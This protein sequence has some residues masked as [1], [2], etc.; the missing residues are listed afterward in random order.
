MDPNPKPAS[1]FKVVVLL[2]AFV[3]IVSAGVLAYIGMP[4]FLPVKVENVSLTNITSGSLSLVWT[5]DRA[6]LASV[7]VADNENFKDSEVF[8]DDRDIFES[9][10]NEY[11]K[12]E[13]T[14]RKVHHVTVRGLDPEKQYF[15]RI[16]NDGQSEDAMRVTTTK[17]V[18]TLQTPD[19][20]YG[21]VAEATGEAVPEGVVIMKKVAADGESQL[22]SAV[23]EEGSYS[24]DGGNMMRAD[25][26]DYF[27][28]GDYTQNLQVLG[29]D[30]GLIV[31]SFDVNKDNDQPVKDINIQASEEEIE[32][33]VQN[34][35]EVEVEV[36][37]GSYYCNVEIDG[38]EYSFDMYRI[39]KVTMSNG[40]VD[41]YYPTEDS[42]RE[43][44]GGD[45]QLYQGKGPEVDTGSDFIAYDSLNVIGSQNPGDPKAVYD[46]LTRT[47]EEYYQGVDALPDAK[48]PSQ[49]YNYEKTCEGLSVGSTGVYGGYGNTVYTLRK[50][51]SG[52]CETINVD[53]GQTVPYIV[54][55]VNNPNCS[56]EGGNA[57][58]LEDGSNKCITGNLEVI[59]PTNTPQPSVTTTATILPSATISPTYAANPNLWAKIPKESGLC[60]TAPGSS[61]SGSGD[62]AVMAEGSG[63]KLGNALGKS[64]ACSKTPIIRTVALKNKTILEQYRNKTGAVTKLN[65][66]V[67]NNAL[68]KLK[69]TEEK[70]YV[71]KQTMYYISKEKIDPIN[72]SDKVAL[73]VKDVETVHKKSIE[74]KKPVFEIPENE[75]PD[76][77]APIFREAKEK[78]GIEKLPYRPGET[79]TATKEALKDYEKKDG[80]GA[81]IKKDP[82][83]EFKEKD[84]VGDTLT[85]YETKPGLGAVMQKDEKKIE[86]TKDNSKKADVSTKLGEAIEKAKDE[87]KKE[88]D[89]KE[90]SKQNT[91]EQPKQEETKKEEPKQNTKEQPKQ[92]ETK[93]EQPK[94]ETKPKEDSKPKTESKS[95][96]VSSA[97]KNAIAKKE[98]VKEVKKDS[99]KLGGK[100]QAMSEEENELVTV[101]SE[102]EFDYNIMVLAENDVEPGT[103]VVSGTDAVQKEFAVVGGTAIVYF[104][105]YNE[106]GIK[107]DDEPLY[108]GDIESLDVKFEKVAESQNFNLSE[109]WNL[110]SFPILLQGENSSEILTAYDLINDMNDSGFLATHVYAYR[111][112]GF[113]PYSLRE[114][115][116]GKKVEFGEKFSIMPGEAYFVRVHN[117]G[118]YIVSGYKIDGSQEIALQNGWNLVSIYNSA[119]PVYA[120][121]DVLTQMST[122]GV[123]ADVL[124]KWESGMYANVIIQN[125]V[126]YGNDFAVFPYEGY[127]L[128]VQDRGTGKFKPV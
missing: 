52:I 50:R 69:E 57:I 42:V 8:Y 61:E 34:E 24:M 127:F 40:D 73:F 85:K 49:D 37:G 126:Q 5:S 18:E 64:V 83:P 125:G 78:G 21:R 51:D 66:G 107:Q 108:D 28:A 74:S 58:I 103:Y 54:V 124:S 105:D 75:I 87:R 14:R 62:I 2:L 102:E 92:E 114:D 33:Q 119:K 100:M 121:F 97:I 81:V 36:Y 120:S 1:K 98:E 46:P 11:A 9:A 55:T 112:G 3:A 10:M 113:V 117:P 65:N 63:L 60:S 23:L 95:D 31:K 44:Q 93:K 26:A 116:E 13:D 72:D 104:V 59:P 84:G 96:K 99:G 110:V 118:T 71:R 70:E 109:G 4:G 16:K 29:I 38:T 47:F 80:I 22:V 48:S 77:V 128:R 30:G 86:E 45:C 79:E 94:T 111:S 7:E 67:W 35:E 12:V 101:L 106:D 20:V 17:V 39:N 123:S 56:G 68:T 32:V 122:S 76:S 41:Y 19:P 27:Q 43:H 15:V 90:D 53:L 82:T 25:F 6:A 88:E 115:A 91:K 89:K